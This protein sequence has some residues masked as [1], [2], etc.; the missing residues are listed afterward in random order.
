MAAKPQRKKPR[1]EESTSLDSDSFDVS[2]IDREC[3]NASVHGVI[4][5]V[6]PIHAMKQNP[7]RKYFSACVTD[8]KE[9]LRF[10]CFN[11][12]LQ[13]AVEKMR[14]RKKPCTIKNCAIKCSTY[15]PTAGDFELCYTDKTTKV[16]ANPSKKFEISDDKIYTSSRVLKRLSDLDDAR[17]GQIVTVHGKISSLTA[18]EDVLQNSSGSKLRKQ[19]CILADSGMS[20]PLK[21]WEGDIGQVHEGKC[22]RFLKVKVRQYKGERFLTTTEDS[23]FEEIDDIGEITMEITL[24]NTQMEIRGQIAAVSF[25]STYKACPSCNSKVDPISAECTKCQSSVALSR[26]KDQ[27]FAKFIVQDESE[28]PQCH[29]VTAFAEVISQIIGSDPHTLSESQ[30]KRWLCRSDRA[31][32]RVNERSIITSVVQLQRS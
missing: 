13:R 8:G 25:V 28:V 26:C 17:K 20:V 2:D 23:T 1:L 18:P 22:Y 6:S 14:D 15:P 7:G 24:P 27:L 31:L 4:V 16:V 19:E 29:D 11:P 30:I 9:T 32:F 5:D 12:A 3:T 21:I 10:V